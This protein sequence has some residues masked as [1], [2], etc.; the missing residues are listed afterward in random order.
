VKT[1]GVGE[2]GDEKWIIEEQYYY[3]EYLVLYKNGNIV[4]L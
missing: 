3:V 2:R 4:Y 1:D